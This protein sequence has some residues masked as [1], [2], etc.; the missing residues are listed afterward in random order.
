MQDKASRPLIETLSMTLGTP[1]TDDPSTPQNIEIPLQ[2]ALPDGQV[3]YAAVALGGLPFHGQQQIAERIAAAWNAFAGV[4]TSDISA[5]GQCLHQ[6][7]EPAA[8]EQ[9][10][11]HAGLD[12]GRAQAVG[13][14]LKAQHS[15]ACLYG[16]ALARLGLTDTPQMRIL[17]WDAHG[18]LQWDEKTDQYITPSA[19]GE[20]GQCGHVQE[21]ASNKAA[22]AAV[23][24]PAQALT[25]EARAEAINR[26]APIRAKL[27]SAA[28]AVAVSDER[29]AFEIWWSTPHSWSHGHKEAQWA[30][31]QA[32]AALA[33]TPAAAP[34]TLRDIAIEELA[35]LGYTFDGDRMMPPDFVGELLHVVQTATATGLPAQAVAWRRNRREYHEYEGS[36]KEDTDGFLVT[37]YSSRQPPFGDGWE[38]L[39]AAPLALTAHRDA[40]FE[41]VRKAFCKLQ[42][43]SFFLDDKG[44]VRRTPDYCG[45]WVEFEAVHTLFEPAAVEAAL[46]AQAAQGGE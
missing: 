17:F 29:A 16:Y 9:A 22:P 42:R 2:V 26:L 13:K 46:A 41:A 32:R 37:D 19:E 35:Q 5:P 21:P 30:A 8:A 20:C 38:P 14:E 39:Y 10:A 18:A 12:E 27:A 15:T 28:P 45:N 40:A 1:Y 24:V 6:I 36:A 4:A 23:A 11:W 43:Y 7:Q 25:G 3:L 33:A 34:D 31:W 44:N